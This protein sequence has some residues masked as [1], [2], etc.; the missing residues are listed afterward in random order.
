MPNSK[1]DAHM[2]IPKVAILMATYNGGRYLQEQ[3]DS[4][5][6]QTENNWVLWA[7]DDGS[8]DD[9]LQILHHFAQK[10]P[11]GV[12]NIIDG[13][14]TGFANNFLSLIHN[15]LVE[16]QNFAFADQD[17]VWFGDKLERATKQLEKY[18]K[19]EP[20]LYCSRTEYVDENLTHIGFSDDYQKPAIFC[21]ALVQNIA[22]GNTIVFNQA[23]R[24]LLLSAGK[25][26]EIPLHDW[27]TYM[28]VTAC[29]GKTFFDRYPTVYYRQ[30]GNNLWGMNTGWKNRSIRIKKLFEGRFRGWNERHIAA[31]GALK[32]NVSTNNQ[33]ILA[34]FI[35]IREGAL[36]SRLFYLKKSGLYRQTFLGNLGLWVGAIF[37]KI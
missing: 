24:S 1:A 3:L 18:S 9:T 29:G 4:F 12:I 6:I 8:T 15:P 14:R 5:A 13:P 31:L 10:F 32:G 28:A 2:L 26:I 11:A 23:C 21:N 25:E 7:S 17:D 27:W 37:C 36:P 30:H 20:A 22:S 19:D 33:K 35:R 16:A 34:A